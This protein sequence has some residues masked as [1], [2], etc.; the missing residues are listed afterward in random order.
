[1]WGKKAIESELDNLKKARQGQRNNTLVA[2]SYRIGK[3]VGHGFITNSE[4]TRELESANPAASDEPEKSAATIRR[5]LNAGERDASPSDLPHFSRPSNKPKPNPK[6]SP[7]PIALYRKLSDEIKIMLKRLGYNF[8][9][10]EIDS[11][12]VNGEKINDYTRAKIRMNMRDYGFKDLSAIE[13]VYLSIAAENSYHPIQTYLQNLEWDGHDHI[14]DLA[15][16]FSV[17]TPL[18]QLA[19]FNYADRSIFF[20]YLRRWLIGSVAKVFRGTQNMMLV[21]DGPQGIGKS[22]LCKW[23]ASPLK[24]YFI[25]SSINPD[26]KDS[27]VRLISRWIW[28]VA[29][30]GAT[31]RHSDREALKAFIT[32]EEVTVRKAYGRY[33][34]VKPAMA[35]LIGTINNDVGFLN[36]ST[37]SR[38]FTVTSIQS[39][40]WDYKYL[41]VNQIW[42]QAFFSYTQ[43]ETGS[44]TKDESTIQGSINKQYEVSNAMEE[45][46]KE[47]FSFDND[48]FMSSAEIVSTLQE[49]DMR[50]TTKSLSMQVSVACKK[51]GLVRIRRGGK[52]GYIGIRRLA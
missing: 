10:N 29:E 46:M 22:Y 13:D 42:A 27:K 52:R 34:T 2:I 25:E 43:G 17:S 21:M 40:D 8:C 44:L 24:K 37:G 51:I 4:A 50:G 36:D 32:T 33:D 7:E 38:R 16:Y 28:E 48:Q 15:S 41:D 47:H 39:I 6:P 11:V 26:D 5:Q 35:S 49:K 12:E 30:L 9:L 20:V 19:E 1:L 31:T 23:L 18:V 45:W 3:M 14:L